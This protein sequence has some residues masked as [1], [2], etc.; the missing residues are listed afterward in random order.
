M[1]HN[2]N[3]ILIIFSIALTIDVTNGY[4]C[5]DGSKHD[6]CSCVKGFCNCNSNIQ[7]NVRQGLP[8][9]IVNSVDSVSLLL[10]N[11]INFAFK[12]FI[13]KKRIFWL[14]KNK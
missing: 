10:F 12:S 8:C 6:D 13:Y 7:E 3:I 4:N 9:R 14:Y 2:F 1:I 5:F 11:R